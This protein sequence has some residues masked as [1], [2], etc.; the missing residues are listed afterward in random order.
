MSTPPATNTD[1]EMGMDRVAKPYLAASE[2]QINREHLTPA[3]QRRKSAAVGKVGPYTIPVNLCLHR[4]ENNVGL[5]FEEVNGIADP[6]T[7]FAHLCGL[8]LSSPRTTPSQRGYFAAPESPKILQG[9]GTHPPAGCEGSAPA[10]L[11]GGE[12]SA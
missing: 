7:P 3:I 5:G 9:Q 10:D 1:P 12:A 2:A 6:E 11:A 8:N 4:G